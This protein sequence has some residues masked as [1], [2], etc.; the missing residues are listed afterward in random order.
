MQGA[1]LKPAVNRDAARVRM[2]GSRPL[3]SREQWDER[4]KPFSNSVKASEVDSKQVEARLQANGRV[5]IETQSWV[6]RPTFGA[7]EDGEG[8][9]AQRQ[10]GGEAVFWSLSIS[11]RTDLR[12]PFLVLTVRIIGK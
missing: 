2:T 7:D 5:G 11:C 12:S 3:A 10:G 8:A 1:R 9:R 4:A 6:N